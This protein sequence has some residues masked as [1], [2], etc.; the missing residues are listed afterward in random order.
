VVLRVL[1]RAEE[2]RTTRTTL[3]HFLTSAGHRCRDLRL[4]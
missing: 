1:L 4:P 2:K 3:S